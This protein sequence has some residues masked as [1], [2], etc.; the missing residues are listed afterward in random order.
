MI[1]RIRALL[2]SR[3]DAE[4]RRP[5]RADDNFESGASVDRKRGDARPRGLAV[6]VGVALVAVLVALAVVFAT[7]RGTAEVAAQGTIG[8]YDEAA[9]SAAAATRN[10]T[11]QALVLASAHEVGVTTEA[12][13]SEGLVVAEEAS[14]ELVRR[15]ERLAEQL[16]DAG[17]QSELEAKTTAFTSAAEDVVDRVRAGDLAEANAA[18]E[19]SLEPKYQG[20]ASLLAQD[21]DAVIGQIAL[22]QEEA[23]RMADAARFLV[24]F[25]VP[26]GA[27]FVYRRTARRRQRRVELEQELAKQRAIS[28]TKDE[29]IANLSHELRT[30]LTSIYGFAL[31]MLE[32]PIASEPELATELASLIAT[33]ST[34]LKRMV[35]DLLTAATADQDGLVFRIEQV[36]PQ[37]EVAEVL[38]PMEAAGIEVEARLATELVAVDRLQLRQILRNLLSNAH[39]HGAPPISITGRVEENAYV[40]AVMDSGPGVPSE[41]EDRLFQRFIHEGHAPL[42]TGSVGLGLSVAHHLASRMDGIIIYRRSKDRTIF[43]VSFPLNILREKTMSQPT[44]DTAKQAA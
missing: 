15:V 29:F 23:G 44:Q 40:F 7:A 16:E 25:L 42:L 22:A 34:E 26:I 3:L 13:L 31:A 10:R 17:L 36:D 37:V 20:L 43:E 6:G 30:P 11:A 8:I 18:V 41:L 1:S 5:A 19:S 35:D 28:H 14:V 32:Q 38:A 39:K 24:A 2:L 27:I 12:E 21:R 33:E 9:L 4:A